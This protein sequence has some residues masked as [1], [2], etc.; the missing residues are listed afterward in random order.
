MGQELKKLD[1]VKKPKNH[2]V[3][4]NPK[5]FRPS[6][7]DLLIGDPKKAKERAGLDTY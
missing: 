3:Y 6:E 1:I 4:V 7:V 5:Y 2:L